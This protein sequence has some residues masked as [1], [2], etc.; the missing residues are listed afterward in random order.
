MYGLIGG[1]QLFDLHWRGLLSDYVTAVT[2]SPDGK[3][4]AATSASGEVML[5]QGLNQLIT[6][7]AGV[8]KSVDCLAFSQNGQLLATGGQN[9]QVKIW[10]LPVAELTATFDNAPI[11]VDKLAWSPVDNLLAFSL[12]RCVQ[13]WDA[14]KSDI[15]VTLNF[16]ASSVFDIDWHP[17]GHSLTVGG[18]KGA[19]IWHSQ[20]WKEDPYA[21]MVPT[22]SLA[23]AWSPDGKYLASGNFDRTIS[24]LEWNNRQIEEET[25]SWMMRGLPGKV[26]KLA[27]SEAMTTVGAPLLASCSAQDI[28]VWSKHVDD[29]VGWQGQELAGHEG[30][31]VAIAFQPNT[32]LLASA[33]EDGF[34]CLWSEATQVAQILDDASSGC[35]CL[36][37]HPQG[38][39]LAAGTD[40]GE[41]LIWSQVS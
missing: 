4:L 36:A 5:W 7:A 41:L 13:V 35:S 19:K 21:L 18:Y 1:T 30:V 6:L 8:G 12:G 10:H 20:D 33:A 9:G 24:V 11:W 28:A 14:S 15:A 31:V 17:D 16:E 37:W 32:F 40:N 2:W 22:A 3:T 27:W 26:R 25:G 29:S 39:Q 38:H 34:V 23:I